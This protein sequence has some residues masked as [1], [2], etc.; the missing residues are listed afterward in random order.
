M[1]N[2]RITHKYFF[3][4]NK[5]TKEKDSFIQDYT[6]LQLHKISYSRKAEIDEEDLKLLMAEYIRRFKQE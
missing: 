6:T 2:I 5:Y 3:K 1:G 4:P